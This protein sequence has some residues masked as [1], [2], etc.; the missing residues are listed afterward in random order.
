M[1]KPK[2]VIFSL[3]TLGDLRRKNISMAKY[4]MKRICMLPKYG[5][6]ILIEPWY[7]KKCTA[8]YCMQ[9]T[10][11]FLLLT[12]WL[13]GLA[14][15]TFTVNWYSRRRSHIGTNLSLNLLSKI[16]S[17]MFDSFRVFVTIAM[18]NK[19]KLCFKRRPI[20][21]ILTPFSWRL[22]WPFSMS[23]VPYRYKPFK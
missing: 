21:T 16:F 8:L 6:S 2:V 7:W 18:T 22:H 1:T 17:L 11:F 23:Y 14:I 3:F 4:L 13:W 12:M 20:S 10:F 19:R 9:Y 5:L 15:H